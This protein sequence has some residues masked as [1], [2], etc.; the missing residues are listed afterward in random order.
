MKSNN[1]IVRSLLT[2]ISRQLVVK[3]ESKMNNA[4]ALDSINRK[5]YSDLS[6]SIQL[7]KKL[8]N[9]IINDIDRKDNEDKRSGR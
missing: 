2:I 7:I 4:R 6:R 5:E 9:K 3:I 8:L 1:E